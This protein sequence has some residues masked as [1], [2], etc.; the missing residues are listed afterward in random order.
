V[1]LLAVVGLLAATTPGECVQPS[2][3]ASSK[4]VVPGRADTVSNGGVLWG[5]RGSVCMVSFVALTSPSAVDVVGQRT[6]RRQ[7]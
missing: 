5:G 7:A 4:A 6:T 2:D 3:A 1:A